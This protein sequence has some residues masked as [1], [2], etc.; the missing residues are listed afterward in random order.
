MY[1][2]ERYRVDINKLANRIVP[3]IFKGS[4][5]M[6]IIQSYIYP[7]Q[8]LSD[9]FKEN[10]I[11]LAIEANM[12]SQ[13]MYFEWFLNRKLKKYMDTGDRISVSNVNANGVP[14]F[15]EDEKGKSVLTAYNDNEN[16]SKDRKAIKEAYEDTEMTGK[17]FL[18]FVPESKIITQLEFNN[19]VSYYVDKYKVVGKTYNIIIK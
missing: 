3:F 18:I 8:S 1:N 10:A 12:T 14:V 9:K 19:I 16:V 4:N 17:S 6:K 5:F 7:I 15:N 11:E 2:F 13:T